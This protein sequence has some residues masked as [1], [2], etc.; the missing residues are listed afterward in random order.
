[1]NRKFQRTTFV[2]NRKLLHLNIFETFIFL[3]F[4]HLWK[5]KKTVKTYSVHYG[6]KQDEV[7]IDITVSKWC[8][9]DCFKQSTFIQI[10]FVFVISIHVQRLKLDPNIKPSKQILYVSI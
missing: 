7:W 8:E 5:K 2:W 10:I 9:T 6:E 1:M 3:D 4:D